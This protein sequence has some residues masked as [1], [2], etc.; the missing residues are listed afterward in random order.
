MIHIEKY[1][2]NEFGDEAD[3]ETVA[4]C[5]AR[6][7]LFV[8][9]GSDPEDYDFYLKEGAS[10]STCLACLQSLVKRLVSK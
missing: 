7:T 4:E 2:L 10:K 5:G 9:G 3:S 6:A 8:D 1:H